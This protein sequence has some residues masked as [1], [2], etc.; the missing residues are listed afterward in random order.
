MLSKYCAYVDDVGGSEL[1]AA[2]DSALIDMECLAVR[3]IELPMLGCADASD[4]KFG[5]EPFV[6][7]R[8]ANGDE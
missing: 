2:L 8:P 1:F 3:S 5:F 6:P 7:S 4:D